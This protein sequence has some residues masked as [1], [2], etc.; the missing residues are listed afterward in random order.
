MKKRSCRAR[1]CDG[2]EPPVRCERLN[3]FGEKI[4][5]FAAIWNVKHWGFGPIGKGTIPRDWIGWACVCVTMSRAVSQKVEDGK[6]DVDIC[7]LMW[8]WIH[9][10]HFFRFL[11]SFP[12]TSFPHSCVFFSDPSRPSWKRR[13]ASRLAI[14]HLYHQHVHTHTWYIMMHTYAHLHAMNL[15]VC[16]MLWKRHS[17]RI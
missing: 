15:H 4:A 8:R 3:S 5:A 2:C 16:A 7:R 10:L 1:D 6:N 14:C 9:N 12:Y 13:W 17:D 11:T